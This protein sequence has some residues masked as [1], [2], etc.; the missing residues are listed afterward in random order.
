MAIPNEIFKSL[1]SRNT[2]KEVWSEL[3]KQLEGGA[4]ILKNNRALCI[5]DYFAFKAL[6]NESLEGTY[7]TFNTLVKQ[8]WNRKNHRRKQCQV[9]TESK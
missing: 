7:T 3:H 2:S 9:L 8:V 4:K 6:E 1:D 5:N